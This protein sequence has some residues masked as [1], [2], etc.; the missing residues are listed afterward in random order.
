MWYSLLGS[1]TTK[2][3]MQA[4]W[5]MYDADRPRR[6]SSVIS[7]SLRRTVM[8]SY[9]SVTTKGELGPLGVVCLEEPSASAGRA[10]VRLVG[11]GAS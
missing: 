3:G 11:H 2:C 9:S 7:N 5:R 6:N 4:Y 1:C 10:S 8:L